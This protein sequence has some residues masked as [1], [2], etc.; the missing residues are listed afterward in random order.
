M[1]GYRS[2]FTPWWRVHLR[3]IAIATSVLAVTGAITAGAIVFHEPAAA[4][5]KTKVLISTLATG[6][7]ARFVLPRS[8]VDNLVA[9]ALAHGSLQDVRIDSDGES[10]SR[11]S[12]LTPREGG[13]RS[14]ALNEPGRARKVASDEIADLQASLNHVS[15]GTGSRTLLNGL[16][17]TQLPDAA[18]TMIVSSG[19][20]LEDPLNVRTLAWKVP[21][22]TVVARLR[23][24]QELPVM[25]GAAVTF[26]MV[27]TAG[28]QPQLRVD[29]EQ[30]YLQRLWRAI[31]L[32]GGARS[33]HFVVPDAVAPTSTLRTA[34]VPID[35]PTGTATVTCTLTSSVFL[36]DTAT[37]AN[38]P[39]ARRRIS[40]CTSAA[41]GTGATVRVD[42]WTSFVGTLSDAQAETDRELSRRRAVA[43]AQLVTGF[44]GSDVSIVAHGDDDQPYPADPSSAKNRIARITITFP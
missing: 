43:S 21:A 10:T 23:A 44:T 28:D 11:T 42:A 6:E 8:S 39:E 18:D 25:R 13:S 31:L 32:A 9:L 36:P 16:I 38:E 24:S 27:P 30:R 12:D 40:G 26:V 19:L 20:D 17:R 33:V 41:A 2:P 7:E 5:P 37:F 35:T 14:K 15:G 1:T 34:I 29:K 3:L 22:R 4:S